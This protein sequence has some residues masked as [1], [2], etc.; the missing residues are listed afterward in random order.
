MTHSTSGPRDIADRIR[1]QRARQRR[2]TEEDT[3]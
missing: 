2:D 1:A 3:D